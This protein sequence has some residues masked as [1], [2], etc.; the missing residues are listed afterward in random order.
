[1]VFEIYKILYL[2]K[3]VVLFGYVIYDKNRGKSLFLWLHFY[4][5]S[6]ESM[7]HHLVGKLGS[8]GNDI[9][10]TRVLVSRKDREYS[11]SEW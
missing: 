4:T 3:S 8:V 9:Q 2:I 7:R 5:G 10:D 11:K 6:S 1:M